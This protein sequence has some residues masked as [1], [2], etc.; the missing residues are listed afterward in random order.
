M[1]GNGSMLTRSDNRLERAVLRTQIAEQ[2][3]ESPCRVDLGPADS[4]LIEQGCHR[5]RRDCAGPLEARELRFILDDP[6]AFDDSRSGA[7][8]T[9]DRPNALMGLNAQRILDKQPSDAMR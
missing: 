7:D 6:K 5:L 9:N 3:L 1:V 8:H 4:H 2:L